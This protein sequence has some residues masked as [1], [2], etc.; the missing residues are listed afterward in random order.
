ML[1]PHFVIHHMNKPGR[2]STPGRVTFKI[3][4]LWGAIDTLTHL[5]VEPLY[6]PAAAWAKSRVVVDRARSG[7]IR[8]PSHTAICTLFFFICFVQWRSCLLC[9]E[10]NQQFAGV[11]PPVYA[12]WLQETV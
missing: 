10:R 6:Q 1:L 9:C 12:T 8:S 3:P 2:P 7:T 11:P 5:L 4:I